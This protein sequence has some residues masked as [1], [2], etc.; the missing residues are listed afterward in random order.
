MPK[1]E[2]K[3]ESK[4]DAKSE[5]KPDSKSKYGDGEKVLCYHG[6]LLYEAKVSGSRA[7]SFS[8]LHI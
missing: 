4:S 2:S 3:S 7:M 1:S 8:E 6:K 5:A